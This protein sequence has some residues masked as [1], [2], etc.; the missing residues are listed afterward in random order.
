MKEIGVREVTGGLK[1]QIFTQFVLES[2]IIMLLALILSY[3][4]FEV[5]RDEALAII[6]ETDVVDLDP[7]LPIYAGFIVFALLIG[8]VSGVVPALHF[9]KVAPVNA[10]K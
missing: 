10:L 1:R 4:F 9:A 7:T 5:I 3:F 6:G 8:F 2:S